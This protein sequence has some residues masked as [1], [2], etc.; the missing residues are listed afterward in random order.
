MPDFG[1]IQELA[2]KTFLPWKGILSKCFRGI[3]SNNIR[4]LF[5]VYMDIDVVVEARRRG[6]MWKHKIFPEQDT[7]SGSVSVSH[8]I[9]SAL[10]ISTGNYSY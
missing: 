10:G 7:E 6:S 9:G 4:L 2:V 1:S 5:V 3:L 8:T